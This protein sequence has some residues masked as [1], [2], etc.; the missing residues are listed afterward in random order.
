M[1]GPLQGQIAWVT[2]AGSGIGLAG[3]QALAAAGAT[4][5]LS[6]RRASVL[7]TAAETV[8]AQGGKAEVEVLDVSDATAV[9]AVAARILARH[10]GRIDVLLN[11]AGTN[12]PKRF[13]RDQS[14]EGWRQVLA[15]NLDSIFYTTHAVLP[16]MR[17]R[18]G[19]LVINVSSWAGVHHPKLTGPAYNGSK[20]AVTAMTETINMEDGVHG[21]RAC[22]IC[23]AEVAT[24]ILDTRPVPPS[25]E[26]R[27]RMLQP[28][29]LGRTIRFIAELPPGVCINQLIISP[30]WNRMYVND[31]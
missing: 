26:E 28:D 25:A 3:A 8:R 4:V 1:S 11:S 22:C 6:G 29:D 27:S 14:V 18:G 31:L 15:T 9:S 5:V 13:W 12:T 30:A 17:A 16:A 23:P 21:I 19:G 10:A 2:G 24:P 7:E 20:H